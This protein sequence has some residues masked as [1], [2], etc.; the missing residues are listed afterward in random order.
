M[1]RFAPSV[2]NAPEEVSEGSC[3][4]LILTPSRSRSVLRYSRWLRRRSRGFPPWSL[5]ARRAATRV[6][7]RASRNPAFCAPGGWRSSSGGISPK[8]RLFKIFC[9]RSAVSGVL[10]TRESSSTRNFP[11]CSMGPW[12][13][14]QCVSKNARCWESRATAG[15]AAS[16]WSVTPLS[17]ME[18]NGIPAQSMQRR[19]RARASV[20]P[21]VREQA[22]FV[23]WDG[24]AGGVAIT[25]GERG[26]R[27]S[28]GAYQQTLLKCGRRGVKGGRRGRGVP[29]GD[30]FWGS[31]GLRGDQ[32]VG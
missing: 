27:A 18:R 5:K 31:D 32:G 16:V 4:T 12:H 3:E 25:L 9:Q 22:G 11:F 20:L 28:G 30:G 8:L 13:F 6:W 7:E 10:N 26:N 15:R 14:W 21:G 24:V 1:N 23:G 29:S 19:A 2:S 17:G